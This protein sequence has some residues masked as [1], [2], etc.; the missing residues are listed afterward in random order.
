MFAIS[1]FVMIIVDYIIGPKAEFLNAYSVVQ[2]LVGQIPTHDESM[3]ALYLGSIGE[4]VVVIL[5]NFSVGALL[6][7]FFRIVFSN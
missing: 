7:I 6:T 1:L 2:R 4:F 3:V 5:V